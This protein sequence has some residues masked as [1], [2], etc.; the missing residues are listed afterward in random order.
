MLD[1]INKI[2]KVIIDLMVTSMYLNINIYIDFMMNELYPLMNKYL[3][4]TYNIHLSGDSPLCYTHS[5]TQLTLVRK[6]S[7]LQSTA[8][9]N[10]K[11]IEEN[12]YN[13]NHDN[14]NKW[15][16]SSLKQCR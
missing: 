10:L 13:N 1:I 6:G 3:Y 8:F 11:I 15:L 7:I 14:F 2:T 4:Q 16:K 9:H 5:I 12:L